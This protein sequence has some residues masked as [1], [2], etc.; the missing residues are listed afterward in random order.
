[1]LTRSHAH[2]IDFSFFDV[3]FWLAREAARVRVNLG[4]KTINRLGHLSDSFAPGNKNKHLFCFIRISVAFIAPNLLLAT[5][6]ERLAGKQAKV[7]EV[8]FV[9]YLY[10]TMRLGLLMRIHT[11][12]LCVSQVE[13]LEVCVQLT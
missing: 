3:T 1:M 8:N 9:L 11:A 13:Y 5:R 12:D 7:L 4:G 2:F 6:S 10:K